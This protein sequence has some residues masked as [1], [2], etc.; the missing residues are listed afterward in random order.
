MGI[1][2]ADLLIDYRTSLQDAASMFSDDGADFLR[3]LKLA[4][5]EVARVKRPRTLTH[6]VTI[7]AGKSE[8]PGVV[9][10]DLLMCKAA[11]WGHLGDQPWRYPR[12]PIP[13]LS[14]TAHTPRRLVLTPAPTAE[15]VAAFGTAF[16]FFYLAGHTFDVAGDTSLTDADRDLVILRAQAEAMR[17][18][19]IRDVAKPVTL[20]GGSASGSAP[21]VAVPAALYQSLLAE[22][23]LRQ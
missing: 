3:H 4:A 7:E 19:A 17:E 11:T 18:L 10:D 9:P 13:I 6:T 8:Y 12:G 21:K 16:T 23:D 1:A 5:R 2:Y 20:R 15:Q 14:V 22:W